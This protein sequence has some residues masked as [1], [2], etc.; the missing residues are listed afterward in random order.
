[1]LSSEFELYN[2]FHRGLHLKDWIKRNT[3][4]FFSVRKLI[5]LVLFFISSNILPY[6]LG[7]QLITSFFIFTVR[8]YKGW[9]YT[10][11]MIIFNLLWFFSYIVVLEGFLYFNISNTLETRNSLTKYLLTRAIIFHIACALGVIGAMIEGVRLFKNLR[12]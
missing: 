7:L 5:I 8:P 10:N 9:F 12:Y 4:L 2:K 6:V 11:A 3:F 1:M